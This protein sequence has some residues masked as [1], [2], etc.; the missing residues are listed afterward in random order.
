VV[1]V[2]DVKI[3]RGGLPMLRRGAVPLVVSDKGSKAVGAPYHRKAVYC[4]VGMAFLLVATAA[5]GFIF[6]GVA[7]MFHADESSQPQAAN[8]Q[9]GQPNNVQPP[10]GPQLN[11]GQ[12]ANPPQP[13]PQP[14][15]NPAADAVARLAA[16]LQGPDVERRKAAAEKLAATPVDEKQRP[17]VKRGLE[18]MLLNPDPETAPAALRALQTWGQQDDV[19]QLQLL[20][21]QRDA[22]FHMLVIETLARF[23]SKAAADALAGG[24]SDARDRPALCDALRAMGAVAEP[25]VLSRLAIPRDSDEKGDICFLLADIGTQASVPAL[26]RLAQDP[27]LK[28]AVKAAAALNLLRD[29]PHDK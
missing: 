26:Q 27:D 1:V 10:P 23:P 17:V 12:P 16:D 13:I 5:L 25:S 28:V 3:G 7:S 19:P 18:V 29:R 14:P 6:G 2:G 22:L 15:P 8:P 20:L 11:P 4:W 21:S 24:L 9:P